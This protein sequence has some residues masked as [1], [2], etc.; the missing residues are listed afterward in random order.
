MSNTVDFL[1]V[2][3]VEWGNPAFLGI[4]VFNVRF[5]NLKFMISSE[6]HKYFERIASTLDCHVRTRK[7][8]K[9]GAKNYVKREIK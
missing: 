1:K 7:N 3:V 4:I 8:M 9:I 5:G 6:L 2:I